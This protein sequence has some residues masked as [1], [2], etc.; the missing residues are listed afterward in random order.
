[1]KQQVFNRIDD[2]EVGENI[3][4]SCERLLIHEL[5]IIY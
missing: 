2:H 4:F 1:M 3:V 5:D